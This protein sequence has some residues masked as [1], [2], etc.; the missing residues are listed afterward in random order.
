MYSRTHDPK[1]I[2]TKE[3]IFTQS[4]QKQFPT[5]RR[6]TQGSIRVSQEEQGESMGRA[7]LVG[8]E[9]KGRQ[10]RVD[11]LKIDWFE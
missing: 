3:Y 8:P 4:S 7:F 5:P 11:G 2:V 9:G 1:I 6:A 10:G